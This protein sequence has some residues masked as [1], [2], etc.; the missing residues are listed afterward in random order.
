MSPIIGIIVSVQVNIQGLITLTLV[1]EEL[2]QK[3]N[4]AIQHKSDLGK[5][6]GTLKKIVN[7]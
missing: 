6:K 3:F 7:P 2:Q 1:F 5:R 4:D